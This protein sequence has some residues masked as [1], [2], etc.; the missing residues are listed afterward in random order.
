MNIK[1][2]NLFYPFIVVLYF[3]TRLINYKIVPIFVDEAIYIRWAQLVLNEPAN[4]FISLQDGKQPLFIW[5][6]AVSQYF[7]SDPLVATRFVSTL[8]GLGSLIAIYLLAK[9]LFNK[10]IAIISSLLYVLLPFTLLYDR[11]A[12]FDSLLTM[13]IIYSTLF[14]VK[15]VKNANINI[16]ILNGFALGMAMITKS[17]GLIYLYLLPFSLIL[18]NTKN[19]NVVNRITKWVRYSLITVVIAFIIYNLLRISPLFY[20]IEI[21][22]LTFIR[23]LEDFL[24]SPFL[25]FISNFKTL[26]FWLTSYIGYPVFILFILGVILGFINKQKNIIYLSLLIL[27]PLMVETFFNKVIYPRFIL[28]YF[29]F[30]IIIIAFAIDYLLNKYKKADKLIILLVII[31]LTIPTIS[32]LKLIYD[33][34]NAKIADADSRQYLNSWPSGYG[35]DEIVIFL[36]EESKREKIIVGTEGTF[37]LFPF[38]LQIYFTNNENIRIIGYWPVDINNLPTELLEESLSTKTYLILNENQNQNDNINLVLID[39][40]KK[41]NSNSYMR[42][43]EVIPSK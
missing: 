21:K 4:R 18:L 23:S 6:S 38:S 36:K 3:L 7:I 40:Y 14:T 16:A 22:N 13:F 39:K 17:S 28:F 20:I 43:F 34:I 42:I 10:K 27:A 15:L 5:L 32:S 19:G 33:P 11:L 25:F 9:E 31:A 30:L 41:G 8:A 37:G 2:I 35:V 24:S 12:L 29:P 26:I 1:K